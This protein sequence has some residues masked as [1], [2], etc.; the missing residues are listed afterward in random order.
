MTSFDKD[1]AE[2]AVSEINNRYAIDEAAVPRSELQ[3]ADMAK[4]AHAKLT[5]I[6]TLLDFLRIEA[7]RVRRL[8]RRLSVT[9]HSL[10]SSRGRRRSRGFAIL[11]SIAIQ[12]TI[13]A[14][15]PTCAIP[16]ITRSRLPGDNTPR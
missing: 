13:C 2:N 16:T 6:D 4:A 10:R 9:S 12:C 3:Y 8:I 15:H 7:D 11:G 14:C 5:D 1:Y